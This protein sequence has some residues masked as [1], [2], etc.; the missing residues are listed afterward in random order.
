MDTQHNNQQEDA[1]KE[2]LKKEAMGI[3]HTDEENAGTD[4]FTPIYLNSDTT[5]QTP[6]E[7]QHDESIDP[8]KNN[9]VEASEDDLNETSFDK[10]KDRGQAG[11]EAGR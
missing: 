1:R 2:F 10:M 5:L 9:T 11:I 4:S 7:K 6:E 8:G 3:E